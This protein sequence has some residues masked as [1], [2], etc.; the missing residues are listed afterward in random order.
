[1]TTLSLEKVSFIMFTEGTLPSS[2]IGLLHKNRIDRKH[3][4]AASAFAEWIY[5]SSS[6]GTAHAWLSL[7]L[8]WTQ[9]PTTSLPITR[10]SLVDISCCSI[11]LYMNTRAIEKKGA[12]EVHV[13]STLRR[14]RQMKTRKTYRPQRSRLI[15]IVRSLWRRVRDCSLE[16]RNVSNIRI[17]AQ[18]FLLLQQISMW[19]RD[20]LQ[21]SKLKTVLWFASVSSHGSTYS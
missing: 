18:H 10:G 20:V 2:V 1:M 11:K 8:S 14:H 16:K 5:A 15:D 17:S 12:L 4:V 9:T 7:I 19:I 6:T 21:N 13:R 3:I